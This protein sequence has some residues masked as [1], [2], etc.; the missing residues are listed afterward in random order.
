MTFHVQ[1]DLADIVF[2]VNMDDLF[3]R[4]VLPH[5][6]FGNIPAVYPD[7][8]SGM[9]PTTAN[10]SNYSRRDEDEEAGEEDEAP[11]G[12]PGGFDDK[13]EIPIGKLNKFPRP[14]GLDDHASSTQADVVV[15]GTPIIPSP[16]TSGD[17]GLTRDGGDVTRHSYR[18]CSLTPGSFVAGLPFEQRHCGSF[19]SCENDSQMSVSSDVIRIADFLTQAHPDDD[20]AADAGICDDNVTARGSNVI[21]GN[22]RNETKRLRKEPPGGGSWEILPSAG[23]IGYREGSGEGEQGG[24]AGSDPT[25]ELNQDTEACIAPPDERLSQPGRGANN[26]DVSESELPRQHFLGDD[27]LDATQWDVV[28]EPSGLNFCPNPDQ[29]PLGHPS[30]TSH[31]SPVLTSK[32]PTGGE[33]PMGSLSCCD[34]EDRLSTQ[35]DS[36]FSVC[37][38]TPPSFVENIIPVPT[39][40]IVS[41]E[42]ETM[43]MKAREYFAQGLRIHAP[44]PRAGVNGL[45][46]SSAMSVRCRSGQLDLSWVL[47]KEVFKHI[48]VSND[49]RTTVIGRILPGLL[50]VHTANRKLGDEFLCKIHTDA[51]KDK[52]AVENLMR[53]TANIPDILGRYCFLRGINGEKNPPDYVT[54][55][56]TFVPKPTFDDLFLP[57]IWSM[58][59][60][61]ERHHNKALAAMTLMHEKAPVDVTEFGAGHAAEQS[62]EGSNRPNNIPSPNELELLAIEYDKEGWSAGPS[63]HTGILDDPPPEPPSEGIDQGANHQ[64][65]AVSQDAVAMDGQ[66]CVEIRARTERECKQITGDGMGAIS[67]DHKSY[68]FQG[69][70]YGELGVGRKLDATPLSEQDLRQMMQKVGTTQYNHMHL[71]QATQIMSKAVPIALNLFDRGVEP[72][73][74]NQFSRRRFNFARICVSPRKWANLADDGKHKL[75]TEAN[76]LK[77]W[78]IANNRD[79]HTNVGPNQRGNPVGGPG[80]IDYILVNQFFPNGTYSVNCLF[81][82]PFTMLFHRFAAELKLLITEGVNVFVYPFDRA[83]WAAFLFY[84]QCMT[85]TGEVQMV[86][87]RLLATDTI[88]SKMNPRGS[89][90]N[91]AQT[92]ANNTNDSKAFLLNRRPTGTLIQSFIDHHKFLKNGIDAVSFVTNVI[93]ACKHRKTHIDFYLHQIMNFFSEIGKSGI[94]AADHM[95]DVYISYRDT[96]EKELTKGW[97]I[98][99]HLLFAIQKCECTCP[100]V[101]G[102]ELYDDS[103]KF[104]AAR[105]FAKTFTYQN[106]DPNLGGADLQRTMSDWLNVLILKNGNF[107]DRRRNLFLLGVPGCGKSA[108]LIGLLNFLPQYCIFRPAN[109]TKTAFG[110]LTDYELLIE[111]NDFRLS[112]V[113]EPTTVL[114]V[115]EG[116]SNLSFD[117]KGNSAKVRTKPAPPSLFSSNHLCGTG[118]GWEAE[119]MVALGDRF[120]TI[121]FN[122][123]L[124]PQWRESPVINVNNSTC[125]YCSAVFVC[126]MCPALANHLQL[127]VSQIFNT[128]DLAD[129]RSL[130]HSRLVAHAR[131]HQYNCWSH[132]G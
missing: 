101:R 37:T 109:D 77:A 117:R 71:L 24:S 43:V 65:D 84:K 114:A 128:D 113:L 40:N 121:N 53:E 75:S 54:L 80:N 44:A 96:K 129:L 72:I 74:W 21:A 83:A 29:E 106:T 3:S 61:R 30:T 87:S 27:A 125:R 94:S 38:H 1:Y 48:K 124:P 11:I 95:D 122:L 64:C 20:A 9:R 92:L 86:D 130:V 68:P 90:F 116:Q 132:Q 108:I 67:L 110:S 22:E 34:V 105:A 59:Q 33:N 97:T 123:R 42:L 52:Y 57:H 19:A 66:M 93:E 36:G 47:P 4:S 45:E 82:T 17:D 107:G 50:K 81:F 23:T 18:Q 25:G 7:A 104:A 126:W 79:G 115:T 28:N 58:M 12:D 5:P 8:D 56:A 31:V 100:G 41:A 70:S 15:Q 16:A 69:M 89:S 13:D 88:Y 119:D 102:N 76:I 32:N 2:F 49:G 6:Q 10:A 55:M 127:D 91:V 78:N 51:V 111:W 112:K 131:Q 103:K 99:D 120:I 85:F 39:Q 60:N 46:Q 35:L 62:P 63:R 14:Y 26:E 73:S 98:L 118:L